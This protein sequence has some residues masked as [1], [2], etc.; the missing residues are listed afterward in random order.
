M[1]K[2][3]EK[4]PETALSRDLF[5]GPDSLPLG[6]G[7]WAFSEAEWGAIE[8]SRAKN[9]LTRAWDLGFR[10][11]DTAEA[12]GGGRAEQLIGQALRREIRHN[13][14]AIRIAT[15][16]VV[17]D[18]PSLTRHLERSLRR[19]GTDFVDLFYIHWPRQ[20][21]SLVDAVEELHRQKAR[22]LVHAVGLCNV[23]AE[24][25]RE[26]ERRF[27]IAAVQAGYNLIWRGPEDNLWPHLRSIRVAYSPLGQ[28]LLARRFERAPAWDRNDHRRT[29]PLFQE[30]LWHRVYDCNRTLMD[31]CERERLEPTAIALRWLLGFGGTE[32]ARRVDAAVVG[33]RTVSQLDNLVS[34][35]EE[36]GKPGGKA[37]YQ[38]IT[39]ELEGHYHNLR[40]DLPSL[41]NIFG[42]VPRPRG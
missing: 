14:E 21:I 19:L 40:E 17:R 3:R 35:L 11:F 26:V 7:T 15:K 33:G 29:T 20:G 9:L 24:E 39:S 36:S 12:Y 27:P 38:A 28:G 5:Q 37:R 22:G 8:T 2:D 16:S 10:H 41:P 31:L 6:F 23:T 13:R 18:P 4:R 42:Y 30:P 34:G 1:D 25:Y 32:T